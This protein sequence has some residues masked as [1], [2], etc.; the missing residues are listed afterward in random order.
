MFSTPGLPEKVALVL[1]PVLPSS[2]AEVSLVHAGGV[3]TQRL[4]L[5]FFFFNLEEFN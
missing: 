1:S 3:A 5:L 4:S 2:H